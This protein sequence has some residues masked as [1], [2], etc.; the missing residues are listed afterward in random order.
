MNSWYSNVPA[1]LYYTVK[2]DTLPLLI[3]TISE[4]LSSYFLKL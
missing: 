2:A 3:F 1:V 4:K